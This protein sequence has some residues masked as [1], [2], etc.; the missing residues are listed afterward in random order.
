MSI[1]DIIAQDVESI[2]I[3]RWT[4]VP[5][6]GGFDWTPVDLRPQTVRIYNFSTRN[7]REFTLPEGEVKQ[8]VLGVL[9]QPNADILFG[10]DLRDEFVYNGRTYRVVGV[11][12]YDDVTVDANLQFDCIAV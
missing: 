5:N 11:R 9:A 1:T 6:A 3:T 2:V 12:I 8:I 7:Q 4:K 10:H